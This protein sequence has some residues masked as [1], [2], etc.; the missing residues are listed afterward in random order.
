MWNSRQSELC[1]AFCGVALLCL[2][3]GCGQ[4]TSGTV[5]DVEHSSVTVAESDTLDQTTYRVSPDADISRDG[6]PASLLEIQP[7]DEID[8]TVS[9]DDSG[10]SVATSVE[11]TST[12]ATSGTDEDAVD[13]G[14]D[15]DAELIDPLDGFDDVDEFPPTDDTPAEAPA[16]PMTYEGRVTTTLDGAMMIEHAEDQ[17]VQ[18]MVDD[19]VEVTIDGAAAEFADILPGY[20]VM[21]IADE[22]YGQIHAI[23]IEATS[24][25]VV[26]PAPPA[27]PL[28]DESDELDDAIEP[29]DTPEETDVAPAPGGP[30]P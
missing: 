25:T 3:A 23:R 17:E 2:I 4:G 1:A 11:A 27:E 6:S 9:T 19:Y 8:I 30:Q 20:E 24:A 10:A 13:D 5:V 12:Y 26:D 16:E 7:G 18:V 22:D 28:P 15:D 21:V 14:I 29:G